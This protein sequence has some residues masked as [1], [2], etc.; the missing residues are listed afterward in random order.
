MVA[1]MFFT[2]GKDPVYLCPG[3]GDAV[4]ISVTKTVLAFPSGLT[5]RW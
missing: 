2:E 4:G 1:E 3:L 5:V